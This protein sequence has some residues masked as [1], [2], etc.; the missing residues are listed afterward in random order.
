MGRPINI[1]PNPFAY[2]LTPHRR[3]HGPHGYEHYERYRPWLRDEF[4]FRCVFCLYREQWPSVQTW[5]IDHLH[6]M[7][8]HAVKEKDY[9][10]LLELCRRCNGNKSAKVVPDP[11]RV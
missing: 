4:C 8:K 5:E 3:K 6:P 2:P 9:E 7:A 10:N 1:E 11:C